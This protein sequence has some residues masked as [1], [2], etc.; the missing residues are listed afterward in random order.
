MRGRRCVTSATLMKIGSILFLIIGLALTDN[1]YAENKEKLPSALGEVKK[2]VQKGDRVKIQYTGTLA[3]GS[4]FDKSKPGEA[5]EFIVGSGRMIPGLQ[6]ATEGMTLNGEKRVIIK[7][8]DA[9]GKRD[10]T[11]IKE[12]PRTSLPEEFK[13]EKG[14]EIVLKDKTGKTRPATIIETTD[15]N[16]TIDLNHPLAGKDLIFD[17]KIVGIE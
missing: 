4:I 10:E 11:L 7:A 12:F 3:D 8:E 6:N 2:I 16:V 13:P 14:M 5:L 9:L 1:G 17:I 15:K